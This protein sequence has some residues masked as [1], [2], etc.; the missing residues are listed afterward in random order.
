[1]KGNGV[2]SS[3]QTERRLARPET[4]EIGAPN[5][6]PLRE[7][8][9]RKAHRGEN[10]KRARLDDRGAIPKQRR[11]ALVDQ[12]GLHAAARELDRKHKAGRTCAH[13]QN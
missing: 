1:M 11:R 4:V 13:N 6:R 9:R 10:L 12:D 7:E 5:F 3:P 8:F 2:S